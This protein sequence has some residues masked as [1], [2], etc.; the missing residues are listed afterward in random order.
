[1]S[2]KKQYLVPIHV[3]D[4]TTYKKINMRV[5]PLKCLSDQ[6]GH[7]DECV[8]L[9]REYPLIGEFYIFLSPHEEKANAVYD[10]LSSTEDFNVFPVREVE[11]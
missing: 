8:F 6:K 7:L 11:L 2:S 3:E 9:K 4:D 1:M 10:V 5:R